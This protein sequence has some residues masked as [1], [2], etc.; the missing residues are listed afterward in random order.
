MGREE[1][2][3]LGFETSVNYTYRF[4]DDDLRGVEGEEKRE[5]S[6]STGNRVEC[7][8]MNGSRPRNFEPWKL[9]PMRG[10]GGRGR[11]GGG[12]DR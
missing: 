8:L 11:N 9:T 12:R 4:L 10:G 5:G 6:S 7:V 1:E 2:T 3:W